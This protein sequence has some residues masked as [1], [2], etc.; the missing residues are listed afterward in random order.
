MG[1]LKE[2]FYSKGVG[3]KCFGKPRIKCVWGGGGV[4]LFSSHVL[5]YYSAYSANCTAIC[6]ISPYN[7]GLCIFAKPYCLL[8]LQACTIHSI[9]LSL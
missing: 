4:D 5:G 8:S 3:L 6:A 7:L 9:T 2:L 1:E